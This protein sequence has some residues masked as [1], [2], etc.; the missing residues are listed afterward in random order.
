MR[1][2][3]EGRQAFDE[4]T[5]LHQDVRRAIPPAGLQ[6]QRKGSIG[7]FFEPIVGEW[8]NYLCPDLSA[9]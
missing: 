6:A 3:N 1:L 5:S 9:G 4:F 7:A 8:R 2:W